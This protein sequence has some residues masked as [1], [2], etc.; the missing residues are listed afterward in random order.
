MA[1]HLVANWRDVLKR[2]WSIRLLILAG[3]LSFAEIV[4]PFVP[5]AELLPERMFAVLTGITVAAAFIARLMAQS[6]LNGESK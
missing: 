3:L 6:S 4:L 1:I 2:A 5:G